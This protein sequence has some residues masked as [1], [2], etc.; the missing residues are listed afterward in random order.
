MQVVLRGDRGCDRVRCSLSSHKTCLEISVLGRSRS[1]ERDGPVQNSIAAE[2]LVLVCGR[3][4][5]YAM[6][7]EP[8]VVRPGLWK[9]RLV[10]YR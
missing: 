6:Q 5:V 1:C 7:W 3:R 9:D 10:K 8:A 4:K 2:L